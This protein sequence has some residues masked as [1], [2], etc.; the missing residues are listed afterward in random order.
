MIFIDGLGLGVNDPDRNPCSQG[1]VDLLAHFQDGWD[2]KPIPEGGYLIPTE[3]TL[4]VRGLPQSATG[5]STIFT[6]VNCSRLLGKHL[7]GFPNKILREILK[8][9]SILKQI[10]SSGLRPAFINAYR[11]LF[12]KIKESLQWR[13]SATTVANMAAELPFF[14]IEDIQKKQ[15]LYHDFSNEALIARNFDVPYFTPEDAG[16]ILALT[17]EKYDFILYE[18]FL[19]DRAGHSQKMEAAVHVLQTF[20]IFLKT[21]L[22]SVDQE[23][24]LI[25]LT[26]D[27]GNIED[28]SLKTHT[29]NPAMTLVWGHRSEQ[30]KDAIHSLEDITPAILKVLF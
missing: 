17:S 2:P 22:K 10:K 30:I 27:H 13:L 25:I 20:E 6:G 19:T 4:G 12:F 28:L 23:R 29:R 3:T 8:E 11:P 15:S 14:Q 1:E 24:T 26:S 18:Y 5:Q 9:K 16:K 21:L 7:P